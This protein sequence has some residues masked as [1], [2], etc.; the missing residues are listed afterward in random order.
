[1][2]GKLKKG[3][4]SYVRKYACNVTAAAMEWVC[5]FYSILLLSGRILSLCVWVYAFIANEM[6]TVW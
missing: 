1:M 6:D 2:T 3:A 5:R 4:C